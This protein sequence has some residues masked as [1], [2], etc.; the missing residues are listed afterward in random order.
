ML[1]RRMSRDGHPAMS[2]ERPHSSTSTIA[3]IYTR[4]STEE[5]AREGVSL[6]AQLAECRTYAA[7]QGWVLGSEFQ[8]VLSGTRDDRPAYQAL[9]AEARRH[10]IEDKWAVVV[11][12]ALDR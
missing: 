4:V 9:L 1:D 10:H 5:Q 11:V 3:L 12:A 6:D 7:R 8:D 2:P